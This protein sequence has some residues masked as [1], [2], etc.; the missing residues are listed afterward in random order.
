[1][2]GN[3]IE[4][5]SVCFLGQES[6]LSQEVQNLRQVGGQ[7]RERFGCITRQGGD[8]RRHKLA[9]VGKHV[10]QHLNKANNLTFADT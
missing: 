7:L 10:V 4:Q 1:M 6:Q 2:S 5:N 9:H 8:E 3:V